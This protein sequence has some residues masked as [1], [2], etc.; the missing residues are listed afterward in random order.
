M[1]GGARGHSVGGAVRGYRIFE[2][3]GPDVDNGSRKPF[4]TAAEGSFDKEW[5][6]TLADAQAWIAAAPTLTKLR[7]EFTAYVVA[8]SAT[9]D[10][11]EEWVR[12]NL[13]AT[14]SLTKSPVSEK[15]LEAVDVSVDIEDCR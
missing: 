3:S 15:E 13:H 14:G 7:V 5:H 12:F 8:G 11:L 1:S 4:S 2:W 10:E 6:A 9:E